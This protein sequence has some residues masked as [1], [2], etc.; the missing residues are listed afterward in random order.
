MNLRSGWELSNLAFYGVTSTIML[1]I[2]SSITLLYKHI[3]DS[4]MFDL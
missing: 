4:G 3:S 2:L 1:M